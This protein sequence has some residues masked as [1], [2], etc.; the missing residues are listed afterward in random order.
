MSTINSGRADAERTVL[1]VYFELKA[2]EANALERAYA[3]LGVEGEDGLY[4]RL[5]AAAANIVLHRV[6]RQLPQWAALR[7]GDAVFGRDARRRR[8]STKVKRPVHLFTINWADSAPGFS[9]PMAYY[10]TEVPAYGHVVVTASADSPEM[11]GFCDV[12]VGHYAAGTDLL[13]QARKI[14]IAHWTKLHD[15]GQSRWAYLFD[16]VLIDEQLADE[17]ADDVWSDESD[18]EE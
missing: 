3:V 9:W 11:V 16:E 10:A 1:E 5:D 6:Q 2:T 14:I 12:A 15:G 13:A 18:D 8:V 17:W 4:T 7:D